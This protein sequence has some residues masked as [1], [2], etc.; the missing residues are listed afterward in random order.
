MSR[1]NFRA[2]TAAFDAAVLELKDGEGIPQSWLP[3][4]GGAD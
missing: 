2:Y 3:L 4:D 1:D